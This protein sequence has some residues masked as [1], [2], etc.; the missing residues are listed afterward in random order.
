MNNRVEEFLRKNEVFN[1]LSDEDL[2]TLI[3]LCEEKSFEKDEILIHEGETSSSL[4]FVKEGKVSILKKDLKTDEEHLI[5][6]FGSNMVVGEMALIGETHRSATIKAVE[7][8]G[9]IVLSVDKL[10]KN[11]YRDLLTNLKVNLSKIISERTRGANRVIVDSLKDQ[12]E[13]QKLRAELG[14]VIIFIVS[15]VFIYIF[16]FQILSV[17]KVKVF[18]TALIS[19]PGLIVSGIGTILLFKRSSFPLSSFGFNLDNGLVK[20]ALQA[21]MISIP[22]LALGVGIKWAL[23]RF[24]PAFHDL[25]LIHFGL[26]GGPVVKELGL[27]KVIM[28]G[29]SYTLFV[30]VQEIIFRG[31]MQSSLEMFLLSKKK[32]LIAIVI[33]NLPFCMFHL[34]ISIGM[35]VMAFLLGTLWGYMRSIQGNLIGAMISHFL[36]GF[37]GFFLLKIKEVLPF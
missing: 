21:L 27:F 15:L 26:L 12:L 28:I 20:T 34:H 9:A 6:E 19:I 33:S 10:C 32:R 14:N 5:Q 13:E 22:V 25:T 7:K 1:T 30:P 37:L 24:V 4:F 11:K 3:P 31:G 35:S 16:S 29:I 23:I 8:V 18:T 17:L 36:V 2:E